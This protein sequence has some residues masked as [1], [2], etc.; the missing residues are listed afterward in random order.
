MPRN[1]DSASGDRF[2]VVGIGASAGGVE[3]LE[4]FFRAMPADNGMAFVVVTHLDPKRTSWLA[5]I[6]GRCSA[7]PATTAQDGEEVQ[8]QHVYVLP[9]AAVLTIAEGRL[10]VRPRGEEQSDRAPIDIFFRALAEDAAEE[11][12][13]IVLSGGGHDGTLGIRAIKENGGLTLAQG[14]DGSEPRFKEMPKS[15]MA[16]G[17]VDLEVPVERMPAALLRAIRTAAEIDE[18]RIAA[19]TQ[20]IHAVIRSRIGHDFSLYKDKTFGRRVQRRM[21]VLQLTQIDKYVERLQSDADEAGLLFRDLLIG[22]T[23][24]FRDPDAFSALETTV[25]AALFEGKGADDDIRVWVPGCSTGEEAYSIA[26]LL[27]EHVAKRPAGPKLQI[28]ATDIDEQALA[29]ARAGRYPGN[30]LRDVSPERLKRFFVAEGSTF[31]V[32]REIRDLCI[33]S[34]HSVI[35]DPPFSRVD[36]ISCRNLLIY[37]DTELQLQLFPVFHY[38]LRPNGF[39]FLGQSETVARHG[40]LFAPVDKQHRIF[41]RR[42]IVTT[43]PN[44]LAQFT[45]RRG[46]GDLPKPWSREAEAPKSGLLRLATLAVTERFTPAHVVVNEEGD[47]LHY[48]SRTGKYLETPPGPPSRN[49][50]GMTRGAFRLELRAALRKAVE[51]RHIVVRDHVGVEIQGNIQMVNVTVEP[52]TEGKETVFLIVFTDVGSARPS[53]EVKGDGALSA[54]DNAAVQQLEMELRETRERLQATIEELETSNEELKSSNEELLSVNEEIQS[55][56]EE[57]ETSKEETQSINEELQTVNAELHRKVEDLDHANNDLR[58]LFESTEVATMFLDRDFV[59][60]SFTPAIAE[61]FNVTAA[62]RGRKLT[63]FTSRLDGEVLEPQIRQVFEIQKPVERRVTANGGAVHYLMRI[64]PYRATD[65]SVDG[66]LLT[67]TGITGII[68]SEQHQK[69]L[70]AELS[71]RVKNTLTVVISIANQTASRSADLEAFLAAYLGRLHALAFTHDLL[72]EREWEAAPL[73]ELI[74]AELAPYAEIGSDRVQLDGPS[75][76]LKPRAAVSLGMMLHELATNS[77]KYGAFSV[78]EGCV[79]IRW[80]TAIHGRVRRFELSW[81]ESGGPPIAASVKRGFGTELIERAAAFELGGEAKLVF[82]KAGLRCTISLPVEP[83]ILL[84]S[85]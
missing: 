17:L 12:I 79:E 53:E 48:S 60:R 18:E 69:V 46:P 37:L 66:V 51:S 14:A 74:R 4:T 70:S 80:K 2:P 49:L 27:C 5:E 34:S 44:T 30:L 67:F 25:V 16:T 58:N 22:V 35:R 19:A 84:P 52:V 13:G 72:S 3:A 20:K 21:Q 10:H 73:L 28:F 43:L 40:D 54:G 1:G 62:D 26:M 63:N 31:R 81:V 41:R 61:I 78:P 82:G 83:E 77:L 64:L 55:A 32:D 76:M 11:A 45:R 39:L 8:P 9:P 47:I 65:N 29:V 7:M 42:D 15:A 33:F 71:H 38:A 24:F 68:A 57:L 75:A 85:G 59:I 23:N 36:L 6:I 50:L 56:N